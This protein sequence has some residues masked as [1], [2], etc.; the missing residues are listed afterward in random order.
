MTG[1]KLERLVEPVKVYN[2]EVEDYHTYFVGDV[3]VLVHN[4]GESNNDDNPFDNPVP[5][6]NRKSTGRTEP[7]TFEE[8]LAMQHVK[9]SP[10][11]GATQILKIT[12]P[13]WSEEG[14]FKYAKNI[15][16]FSDGTKEIKVEIHFI[17]NNI[18]KLFDDF[19]FKD[20]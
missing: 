3:P 11:E 17:Y 6:E 5:T 4:Y 1:S 7:N 10:L 20:Q 16:F 13:T 12:D 14:W 19:K 2:L 15:K 18:L 8:Q 9:F